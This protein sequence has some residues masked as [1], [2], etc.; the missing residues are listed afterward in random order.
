MWHGNT[1]LQNR[2]I[3]ESKHKHICLKH[4]G[5][6]SGETLQEGRADRSDV[7]RHTGQSMLAVQEVHQSPYFHFNSASSLREMRSNEPV[8]CSRGSDVH[9]GGV[10]HSAAQSDT[11]VIGRTD[12][13]V[14]RKMSAQW[15]NYRRGSI[16]KVPARET[17][18]PINQ[19]METHV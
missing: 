9:K 5:A 18:N 15:I 16:A 4:I 19:G 2:H 11:D 3:S 1:R 14:C 8:S 13:C 7:A 17:R 12:G 10:L 6:W